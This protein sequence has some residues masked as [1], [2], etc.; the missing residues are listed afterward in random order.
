MNQKNKYLP[1][2]EHLEELRGRI[3]RSLAAV[4]VCALLAYNFSSAVLKFLIQPVGQLVFTSP[5]E[6]FLATIQVTIFLALLL[7]FPFLGYEI[8]AFAAGA[9]TQSERRYVFIFAPFSL[10]LFLAGVTFGY[11]V[12]VPISLKFLLSFS[13]PALIPMITVSHYISF[14][15]NFVLAFGIV[16]ELPLIVVFLAVIGVASPEFLRQKRKYAIVLI[17]IV[18]A[19]L[20]PPD[21]MSQL[22]MAVPLVIL[23]EIGIL[24]CALVYKEKLNT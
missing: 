7:A 6:A 13:S 24:L 2:L 22:L 21:W 19:V 14:V 11:L 9:L 20:T 1:F 5:A 12:I 4:V 3:I 8:W 16:F 18:S 17:F 15:G 23:Y 10:I